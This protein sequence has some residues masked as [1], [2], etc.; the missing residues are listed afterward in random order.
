MKWDEWKGKSGWYGM[1]KPK[2]PLLQLF[3][4]ELVL[5]PTPHPIYTYAF[6]R[7]TFYITHNVSHSWYFTWWVDGFRLCPSRCTNLNPSYFDLTELSF[8][9]CWWKGPPGALGYR[10]S[11]VQQMS[12]TG[13]THQHVMLS[14][15]N[16]LC[17]K[18]SNMILISVYLVTHCDF[19]SKILYRAVFSQSPPMLLLTVSFMGSKQLSHMWNIVVGFMV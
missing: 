10:V 3:N 1:Q 5:S 6:I 2:A 15:L 13:N 11:A 7:Q 14:H 18:Q 16:K 17:M 19:V 4:Q 9:R 12:A 8:I